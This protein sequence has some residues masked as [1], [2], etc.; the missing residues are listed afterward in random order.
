[1]NQQKEIILAG[2]FSDGENA[3]VS[4]K[5]HVYDATGKI[6]LRSKELEGKFMIWQP[7]RK[8]ERLL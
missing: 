2:N 3:T 8:T 6:L 4:G 5:V 7:I 1:M